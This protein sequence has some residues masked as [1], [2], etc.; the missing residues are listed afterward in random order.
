MWEI[1]VEEY[2]RWIDK[3]II[4]DFDLDQ[5][6]EVMNEVYEEFLELFIRLLRFQKEWLVWVLK[7]EEF[8]IRGGIFVDEMGMGKIV[9]VI[10]FVFVKREICRVVNVF[11][12]FLL[13][14]SS[15]FMLFEVDC[16]FVICFVLALY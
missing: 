2:S 13:L 7:Q 14:L 12:E 16:I 4:D 11:C 6:N 10:V 15:F 1:W 3:Y 8:V 5:Q 9:Q